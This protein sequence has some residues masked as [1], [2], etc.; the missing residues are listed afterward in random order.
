MGVCYFM[1]WLNKDFNE[2]FIKDVI[3]D[4]YK[5]FLR[6]WLR[7][8]LILRIFKDF[9]NFCKYDFKEFEN[10]VYINSLINCYN[11]GLVLLNDV[12]GLIMWICCYKE[13]WKL[14]F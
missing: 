11:G 12:V 3:K 4:F 2:D 9:Y 10:V 5:D 1:W 13:I 7:F 6:L 14:I 8:F